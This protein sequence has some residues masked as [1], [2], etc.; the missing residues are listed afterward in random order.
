MKNI[1]VFPSILIS[2]VITLIT[3]LSIVLFYGSRYVNETKKLSLAMN[4]FTLQLERKIMENFILLNSLKDRVVLNPEMNTAEFNAI[5]SGLFN[6]SNS[7]KSI[8]LAPDFQFTNVYPLEGN[9]SLLGVKLENVPEQ[10]LQVLQA[11]YENYMLLSGPVPL[12]QGGTALLARVP[13]YLKKREENF[14]GIVSAALDTR[15]FESFFSYFSLANELKIRIN[16]DNT[17]IFNNIGEINFTNHFKYHFHYEFPGIIWEIEL[18]SR[19]QVIYQ[20]EVIVFLLIY[21]ALISCTLILGLK[22]ADT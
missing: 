3:I 2:I 19:S 22:K 16:N 14:W 1:K 12:I 11:K 9:E 20:S 6:K 4:Q 13:V 17:E 7:I 21:T 5:A 15:K 8:A 18:F 10:W